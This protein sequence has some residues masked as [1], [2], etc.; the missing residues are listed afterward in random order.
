MSTVKIS[1]LQSNIVWENKFESLKN[2]ERQMDFVDVDT[3]I[4][5]LPETFNTG[6]SMLSKSH[7]EGMDGPTVTWALKQAKDRGK[8]IMGSIMVQEKDQYF[9]RFLVV[10]PNGI[11]AYYDKRHLFRMANE[12]AHFS[13]GKRRV[14]WEYKSFRFCLQVCYD[15]RFPVWSRN[16]GD[17]DVLIYIANWPARR[18]HPWK[19]L[20][21]ARA[22]E[23]Q[24]YVIGVNRIGED[25]NHISYSGDSAMINPLGEYLVE[26][27]PFEEEILTSTLDLDYLN[28]CRSQFPVGLD[29]DKFEIKIE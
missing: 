26:A 28:Q 16:K 18:A 19:T 10:T 17:Y 15:L 20:L 1:A 23:N 5:I 22:M 7:A 4:I 13:E 12:N 8:V 27:T 2:Y 29:G 6:F 21:L 24:A 3:D 25:G 11:E 9:N 14:I